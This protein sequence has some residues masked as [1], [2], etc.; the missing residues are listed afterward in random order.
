MQKLANL[1]MRITNDD[2]AF[3]APVVYP[4]KQPHVVR[5]RLLLE[6][7]QQLRLR[8]NYTRAVPSLIDFEL[9]RDVES[10]HQ[11]QGLK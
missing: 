11:L 3:A 4:K 2:E 9:G 1:L 6:T 8:S 7:L 10:I 5:S